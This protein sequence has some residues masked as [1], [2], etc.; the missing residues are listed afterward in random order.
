MESIR[1][2]KFIMLKPYISIRIL[3]S[4]DYPI[5]VQISHAP[6][7]GI[8]FRFSNS[9]I[10]ELGL[11]SGT[12]A[13][14]FST[15]NLPENPRPWSWTLLHLRNPIVYFPILISKHMQEASYIRTA[16]KYIIYFSGIVNNSFSPIIGNSITD[17]ISFDIKFFIYIW[18][19]TDQQFNLN[20]FIFLWSYPDFK[21]Y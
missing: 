7:E 4:S 16:T 18:A 19:E 10:C 20:R 13:K 3:I 21:E 6:R 9:A 8:S 15:S 12:R 5:G 1:Y 11:Q 17:L 2:C 14:K